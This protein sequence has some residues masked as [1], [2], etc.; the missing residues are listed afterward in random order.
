MLHL[1]SATS[2]THQDAA[3][4]INFRTRKT[5]VARSY[6]KVSISVLEFKS[7]YFICVDSTRIS[8]LRKMK[9]LI[10]ITD[11]FG[12][13]IQTRGRLKTPLGSRCPRSYPTF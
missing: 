10:I 1:P 8:Q 11:R 13:G 7:Y 6:M 2:S 4:K 5:V 3:N 9:L 12:A